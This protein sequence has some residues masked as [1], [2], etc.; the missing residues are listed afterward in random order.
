MLNLHFCFFVRLFTIVQI[1]KTTGRVDSGTN[2]EQLLLQNMQT[3]P[4][5]GQNTWT[6]LL[7]EFKKPT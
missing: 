4:K 7:F 1:G 3:Q 6:P 2:F 5:F